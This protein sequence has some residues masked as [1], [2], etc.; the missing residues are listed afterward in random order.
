M[1]GERAHSSADYED[2]H[3]KP[4]QAVILG[5]N[6]RDYEGENHQPQRQKK[7]Y[8]F[9]A[10]LHSRSIADA[11]RWPVACLNWCN[12]PISQVTSGEMF[13][14]ARMISLLA[15]NAIPLSLAVLAC[16]CQRKDRNVPRWRRLL[17]LAALCANTISSF[18]LVAFVVGTFSGELSPHTS[19]V[20][21]LVMLP[22]GFLSA[23]LAAFGT[24]SSRWLLAGN[25]LLLTVLWYMVGMATSV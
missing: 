15:L 17:F 7:S 16:W 13:K 10:R 5:E 23:V 14:E 21:L 4:P 24:S 8:E 1:D 11:R 22:A 20:I 6:D 9:L 18:A 2:Q 12:I 25:G 3:S 19:G